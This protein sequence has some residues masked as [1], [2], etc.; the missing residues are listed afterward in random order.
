MKYLNKILETNE[1]TPDMREKAE[2]LYLEAKSRTENLP[3]TFGEDA[4]LMLSN[5]LMALIKRVLEGKLIDPMEEE[6]LSEISEKA[7]EYADIIAGPLFVEAGI[8]K[9]RTELFL[10]GTHAE[11]AMAAE[12]AR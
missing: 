2:R 6:M 5:H 7:W 8:E 9:D 1:I 4:Q 3:L 12:A 11:M 10:V